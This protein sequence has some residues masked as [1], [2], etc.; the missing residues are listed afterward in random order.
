MRGR[1]SGEHTR[2]RNRRPR[3]SLTPMNGMNRGLAQKETQKKRY[4]INEC[5]CRFQNLL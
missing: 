3:S 2:M 5:V 1:F 4:P